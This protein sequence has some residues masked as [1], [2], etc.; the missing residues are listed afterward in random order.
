MRLLSRDPQPRPSASV[1]KIFLPQGMQCWG[2][3]VGGQVGAWGSSSEDIG[4]DIWPLDSATGLQSPRCTIASTTASPEQTHS[5]S[6]EGDVE[7][8]SGRVCSR[9]QTHPPV[10]LL[11]WDFLSSPSL[12]P[13]GVFPSCF[14]PLHPS[15]IVPAP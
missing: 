12:E 2:H 7:A 11:P 5:L 8:G 3:W 10:T 15:G 6:V 1:P 14:K 13:D 9:L 4:A